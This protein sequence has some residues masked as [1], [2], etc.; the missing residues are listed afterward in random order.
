[1][2]ST[3]VVTLLAVVA[4]TI[5]TGILYWVGLPPEPAV[6]ELPALPWV[7]GVGTEKIE[8]NVDNINSDDIYYATPKGVW[9]QAACEEV[10]VPLPD[11]DRPPEGPISF[12]DGE[13]AKEVQSYAQIDSHGVS[14]FNRCVCGYK[15]EWACTRVSRY[16]TA[17]ATI[18]GET[19]VR[20][21]YDRKRWDE[22][23]TL[24]QRLNALVVTCNTDSD[25]DFHCG[26]STPP[27]SEW[28]IQCEGVTPHRILGQSGSF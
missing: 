26:A 22:D 14:T 9:Q 21:L 15:V 20:Y 27:V 7:E 23:K 11:P 12:P 17:T 1:M 6:D 18:N 5:A 4:F 28:G 10:T 16:I 8:G 13:N 2:T 3:R 24:R 19:F 25:C